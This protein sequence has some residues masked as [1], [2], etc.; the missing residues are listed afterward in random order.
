MIVKTSDQLLIIYLGS[1]V[2]ATIALHNLIDNQIDNQTIEEQ[3]ETKKAEEQEKEEKEKEKE[4]KEK[5]KDGSDKS[6]IKADEKK[7]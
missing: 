4:E 7:K 1:L 5:D 6:D 2:R 3:N